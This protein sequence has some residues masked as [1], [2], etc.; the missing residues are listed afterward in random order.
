MLLS[1]KA[2]KGLHILPECYPNP[3]L[4]QALS[5]PPFVNHTPTSEEIMHEFPTVFDSQIKNMEGEKF[6]IC[7]ADNAEPFCINTPRAVPFAYWDKLK[8]ELDLLQSQG[9]ISSVTEPTEWCASIVIT[10]KKDSE[11]IR[12]CVNLSRLNKYVRCK[13]CQSSTPAQALADIAADNTKILTKLDAMNG[14]T[15]VFLGWREL[16]SNHIYHAFWPVQIS[17]SSLWHIL[18]LRALCKV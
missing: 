13:R 6:H 14:Y 4:V 10:P 18:Y 7:L 12:M 1:W 8:A 16:T 17:T 5:L 15:P 9:V 11:D 2:A 3:T